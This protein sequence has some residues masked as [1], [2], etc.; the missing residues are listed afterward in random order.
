M[1][2]ALSPAEY[3]ANIGAALD[4]M[5]AFVDGCT[6]QD[7]QSAPL[8]ERGDP[9][10][11]GVIADHVAHAYEYLG[12]WMGQLVAGA[13][14]EVSPA[15]VDGLNAEHAAQAGR[16]SQADVASHLRR[17]G[18]AMIDLV[19]GLTEADLEADGGRV[20]RFAEIAARHAD[21]HRTALEE[22]LRR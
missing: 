2:D 10:A 7:W 20:R 4:R 18:Q 5:I 3:A 15:L 16:L 13:D 17:N 12:G 1:T 8:S 22:A 11:A 14:L 9:R 21:D 19:S 6:E